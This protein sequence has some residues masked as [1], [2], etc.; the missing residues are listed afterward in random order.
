MISEASACECVLARLAS[1]REVT[2]RGLHFGSFLG[3]TTLKNQ[4]CPLLKRSAMREPLL[5][6]RRD[7]CEEMWCKSRLMKKELCPCA[8]VYWEQAAMRWS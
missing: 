2:L 7:A 1:L 5:L 4:Q 3:W 6:W 8:K